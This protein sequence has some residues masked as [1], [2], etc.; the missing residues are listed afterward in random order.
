MS[1]NTIEK[2]ARSCKEGVKVSLLHRSLDLCNK[3][4]ICF[5]GRITIWAGRI[6]PNSIEAQAV[7]SIPTSKANRITIKGSPHPIETQR[8][9]TLLSTPM[10]IKNSRPS[11]SP[12]ATDSRLILTANSPTLQI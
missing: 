11:I 9:T 10:H 1:R 6:M 3:A 2:K 5:R 8:A 4:A 12:K 7:N